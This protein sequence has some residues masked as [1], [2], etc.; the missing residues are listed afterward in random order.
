MLGNND[1]GIYKL[2][3]RIPFC[4]GNSQRVLEDHHPNTD[5]LQGI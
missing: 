1:V 5:E 3:L 4:Y 2:F